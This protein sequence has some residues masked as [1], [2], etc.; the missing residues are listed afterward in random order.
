MPNAQ[1]IATLVKRVKQTA[2]GAPGSTG[3]K[4]MR[5]VQLT[6]NKT[7][8]T[9]E[10][11]EIVDHQMSTG[12]TEGPTQ[13]GGQLQ[14]EL[15]AGTYDLELASMVRKDFAAVTDITSLSITIATSGDYYTVTR[16]T[17]SFLTGGIK[18]GMIVRL[19]AGTFNA[20]N[21]NKNLFVLNVTALALT[22]APLNGVALV[23]EGP[24]ASATVSVPG[25]L[26]WTPT[27]GHTNDYFTWE[28][29]FAD[30]AR[31]ELFTDI[32][33]ASA[34][35]AIPASGIP[36]VNM[37][38]A[39]LGRGLS[40]T[41]TLTSPAAASTSRTLAAKFARLMVD[42]VLVTFTSFQLKLDPKIAVGE[43][44]AGSET[45]SDLQ[46]GKITVSGSFSAKFSGITLQT[47]RE[48]QNTAPIAI[49]AAD[50]KLAAAEFMGFTMP[51]AK[52]MTD[53][54]DDGEK[55]LVRTYNFTAEFNGAGG[56]S[57]A[58]L[59]TILSIQ[60]SLAA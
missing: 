8:E 10:S 33:P 7:G 31:A 26:A 19:T 2:L 48:N 1:G 11:A 54:V 16:A 55:E 25:K 59:A 57:L 32:K 18:R 14:G 20:A 40:G 42:G 15:S 50:S 3:S 45:Y 9:Y 56:A 53:D 38:M 17:G 37:P 29:Y 30:I 43:A 24:I 12:A 34:D 21:L 13:V 4:L 51:A 52:I 58:D 23:A 28:K 44:E 47:L 6:L 5:R 27:T 60:D 39:G 22:V 46:R 35:I 41:E 49:V 36:T